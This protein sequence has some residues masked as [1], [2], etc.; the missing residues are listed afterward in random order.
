MVVSQRFPTRHFSVNS[1]N[2]LMHRNLLLFSW[3][4]AAREAVSTSARA[5]FVAIPFLVIS[6][7]EYRVECFWQ[8]YSGADACC[9]NRLKE[10]GCL[11]FC[12]LSCLLPL[13]VSLRISSSCKHLGLVLTAKW[14]P[15]SLLVCFG[16]GEGI[17]LDMWTCACV[18]VCT[19]YMYVSMYVCVH[20]P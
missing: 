3:L 8:F 12:H 1:L 7:W 19:L 11:C 5:F 14:R 20:V 18:Y 2:K 15:P 10:W 17:V 16:G 9:Q 6:C 13:E 4:L